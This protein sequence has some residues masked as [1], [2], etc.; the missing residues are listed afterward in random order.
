M[1]A[2]IWKPVS[3]GFHPTQ[4]GEQALTASSGNVQRRLAMKPT[5]L[6][7]RTVV[8]LATALFGTASLSEA[9][10]F[11]WKNL[12]S[13]VHGVAELTDARV[14]NPWG[15]ARSN[16]ATIFVVDNG[17][18]VATQYFQNGTP[19]PS[20][21]NPLI[22]TIPPSAANTEGANPTDTVWNDT[23][24]FR[25][26]NGTNTLPAKLIFV[27]EDGMISGWN[28]N[29]DNTHAFRARD[30]STTGAIYKGVTMGVANNHNFLYVTNFHSGHV[31][32]Y[33]ENFVLQTTGFPFDDPNI[34]A[35]Y[36]PFGI[37]NY[38]G[39]I[40]VT[41]A[42]QDADREDDVACRG[43]GFID[44][45]GPHGNLLRRLVSQG[46][47]NAPWGL[48]IANGQLWVGNFGD[49]RINVYDFGNG[50]F[51]GRPKDRFNIPLRFDG[52]WGLLLI[53]GGLY[54]TAGIADEEHGIFGVIF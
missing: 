42:K 35:G 10:G 33:N 26:S 5:H 48:E 50:S 54:F 31:E 29:L 9:T 22:I 11:N 17:T 19:A 20:F 34:P 4:R 6:P 18:G 36:A 8:F 1:I 21:E 51:I 27:S 15:M 47:L 30:R 39:N 52:L 41:Y 43:C 49:G 3:L 14:V 40:V 7:L 16:W 38:N 46:K 13:D 2:A 45:F 23:S 53:D 24:F 28:P 25:V 12:Q 44:V 37:R 32:T